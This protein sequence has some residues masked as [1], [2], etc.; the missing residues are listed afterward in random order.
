MIPIR[1]FIKG[2]MRRRGG[3]ESD[4]MSFTISVYLMKPPNKML[5]PSFKTLLPS[6]RWQHNDSRTLY[7]R[8]YH[9]KHGEAEILSDEESILIRI[10]S[11]LGDTSDG[12]WRNVLGFRIGEKRPPDVEVRMD[13]DSYEAA[14][15]LTARTVCDSIRR[16]REGLPAR[17]IM[18]IR[19]PTI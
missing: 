8:T 19:L 5:D 3:E 15:R 14:R 17:P 9:A 10:Q 1:F 18:D 13:G 4:C 16:Q 6:P 12:D 11:G 2:N 7:V